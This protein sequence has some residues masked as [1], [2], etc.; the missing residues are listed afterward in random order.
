MSLYSQNQEEFK[1]II[2]RSPITWRQK[3][4]GALVYFA[5]DVQFP[6]VFSLR[7]HPF[8]GRRKDLSVLY[9]EID[10][11][12]YEQLPVLIASSTKNQELG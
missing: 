3:I 12:A 6:L 2:L 10:L 9:P 7:F 5:L 8:P 11:P 1:I 4:I